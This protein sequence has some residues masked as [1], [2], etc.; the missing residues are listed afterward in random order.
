MG[1]PTHPSRPWAS[2]SSSPSFFRP[3]G[4]STCGSRIVRGF[5]PVPT[6]PGSARCARHRA[7]ERA[8]RPLPLCAR[9]GL[10][11]GLRQR[12]LPG[13]DRVVSEDSVRRALAEVMA[14]PEAEAAVTCWQQRHLRES[15][16]P[17]LGVPWI[18]IST[19]RSR[20]LRPSGGGRSQLQ[21]AQARPGPPM[22]FT[23]TLCCCPAGPG[24]GCAA[25]QADRGP[26][27][28][29]DCGGC[30]TAAGQGQAHPGAGRLRFRPRAVLAQ[31]EARGRDYLFKL[32]Q[33]RRR[34]DLIRLWSKKDNGRRRPGLEGAKVRFS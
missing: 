27:R 16:G 30:W 2:W 3:A 32:R 26:A 15:Y 20:R 11:R 13:M 5:I 9:L 7:A 34:K 31:G 24:C 18:W 19:R 6:P 14:R 1:R 8:L 4:A 25:R 21:P 12:A 29:Q 17:L 22:P 23:L 28:C 10:A 33:T